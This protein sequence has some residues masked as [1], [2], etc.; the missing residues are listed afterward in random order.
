MP[1]PAWLNV[2]A[3]VAMM[4]LSGAVLFVASGCGHSEL[5]S[6]NVPKD[7]KRHGPMSYGPTASKGARLLGPG[8]S[9]VKP[10]TKP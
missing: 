2:A 4:I 7:L 5:G 1:T 3:R 6:V 10:K 9:R 8:P